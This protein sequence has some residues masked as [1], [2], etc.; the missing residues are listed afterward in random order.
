MAKS[1]YKYDSAMR[2]RI[3]ELASLGYSDT[4]ISTMIGVAR[5]TLSRWITRYELRAAMDQAETDLAS[6]TI[7]RGLA[8]LS[9]GAKATE[10]IEEYNEF[11]DSG[12]LDKDGKPIM[13]IKKITRK[14]KQLAPNEKALEIYARKYAPKFAAKDVAALESKSSILT[15]NVNHSGMSQRELQEHRR[16]TLNPLDVVSDVEYVEL[17]GKDSSEVEAKD[18]SSLLPPI[19]DSSSE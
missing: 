18:A 3:I 17:A 2:S 7:K 4:S 11:Y 10:T 8:A 13:N 1:V 12:E 9:S 16:A 14:T 19:A 15:L 5:S 6:D